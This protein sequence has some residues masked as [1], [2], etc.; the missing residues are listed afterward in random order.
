[1]ENE[2]EMIEEELKSV[3]AMLSYHELE[4]RQRSREVFRLRKRMMKEIYYLEKQKE[5]LRE[6]SKWEIDIL[7]ELREVGFVVSR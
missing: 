4:V 2:R 5:C 1:M 7:K 3:R 6:V